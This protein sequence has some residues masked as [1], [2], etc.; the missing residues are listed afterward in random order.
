MHIRRM[1]VA[2][3]FVFQTDQAAFAT[4]IAQ[5]FPLGFGHICE[6]GIRPK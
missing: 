2:C 4:A 6:F 1:N 5:A 3:I